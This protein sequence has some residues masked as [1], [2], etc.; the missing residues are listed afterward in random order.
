MVHGLKGTLRCAPN[1]ADLSGEGGT[2][3]CDPNNNGTWYNGKWY[4]NGNGNN[5]CMN[6]D[7]FHVTVPSKQARAGAQVQVI[8][9]D[10]NTWG[11]DLKFTRTVEP[12]A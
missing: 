10:S 11:M 12:N 1:A 6:S 3:L 4:N 8:R 7:K 9:T 2:R 5:S